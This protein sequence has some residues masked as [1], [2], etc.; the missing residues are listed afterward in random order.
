MIKEIVKDAGVV[1]ALVDVAMKRGVKVPSTVG[2][3][4][5][6]K[7]VAEEVMQ[8]KLHLIFVKGRGIAIV[9]PDNH[10]ITVVI[11]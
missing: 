8:V 5:M 11:E 7:L 10:R 3:H 6:S 2:L 1:P 9:N 4:A